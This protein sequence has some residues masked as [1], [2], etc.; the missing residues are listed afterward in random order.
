MRRVKVVL[1]AMLAVGLVGCA[2][3]KGGKGG[4]GSAEDQYGAGNIPLAEAGSELKDVNFAFDSAALDSVAK[5]LLKSNAQWLTDNPSVK[6]TVEGHCDERGTAEYNLALG[7]RRAK[8]V[9][10]YMRSSGIA[11]SRMYTVSYG[12]ELPLDPRSSED[13]WS[14]NRRA[15]FNMAR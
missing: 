9:K 10:E 7:E 4:S 14:K 11:D 6:V 5:G 2:C 1:F 8:S 15:H 12:E 13:A 3:S